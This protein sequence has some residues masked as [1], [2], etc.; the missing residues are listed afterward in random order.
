MLGHPMGGTSLRETPGH[1][2]TWGHVPRGEVGHHLWHGGQPNPPLQLRA[3]SELHHAAQQNSCPFFETSHLTQH[4]P[5]PFF[6]KRGSNFSFLQ[7]A[8]SLGWLFGTRLARG[9]AD[10]PS[11]APQHQGEMAGRCLTFS[12]PPRTLT[13]REKTET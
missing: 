4:L 11:L 12:K 1:L 2:E 6:L 5:Q 13:G 3:G 10:K 7:G 9:D 8:T